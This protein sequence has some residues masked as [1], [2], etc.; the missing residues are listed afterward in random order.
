MSWE[1]L[2]VQTRKYPLVRTGSS[3]VFVHTELYVRADSYVW[4]RMHIPYAIP[5]AGTIASGN[6]NL[7][8]FPK[9]LIV[10]CLVYDKICL[11]RP[12]C[13]GDHFR[14][15]YVC[16]CSYIH[17]FTY[18]SVRTDSYVQYLRVCTYEPERTSQYMQFCTYDSVRTTLYVQTRSHA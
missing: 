1:E 16:T 13:V 3:Y 17:L 18:D 7:K 14:G 11:F 4:A 10:Y 9:R 5:T 8:A 15:V 2:Y 6:P 12:T